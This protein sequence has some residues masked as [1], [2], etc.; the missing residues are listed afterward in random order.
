MC[1][2]CGTPSDNRFDLI[3]TAK[4]RLTEATNIESF[5]DEMKVLDSILSRMWQLGWLPES[6]IR[7][8]TRDVLLEM[9]DSPD[10]TVR[11]FAKRISYSM[12]RDNYCNICGRSLRD[13]VRNCDVFK[14]VEKAFEACHADR[15]YLQDPVAE[16][17]S[18]ISFMLSE[19]QPNRESTENESDSSG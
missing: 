1:S 10:E 9:R 4:K 3:E 17:R 7:E 13:E 11:S 2:D 18:T 5:P 16:R 12:A 6:K 15:G 19:W 14:T 8:S